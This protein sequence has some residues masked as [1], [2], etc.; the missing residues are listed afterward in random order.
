[1]REAETVERTCKSTDAKT[2]D[3]SPSHKHAI[4]D[5]GRTQRRTNGQDNCAC[6]DGPFSRVLVG[7]IGTDARAYGRASSVDTW[8]RQLQ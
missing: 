8:L 3:D 2:V 4:V 5:G 1:M 7:G 6:L